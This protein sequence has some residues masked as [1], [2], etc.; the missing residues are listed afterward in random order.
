MIGL[1][2]FVSRQR[3]SVRS[4]NG[5]QGPVATSQRPISRSVGLSKVGAIWVSK[6]GLALFLNQYAFTQ[7]KSCC[8]KFARLDRSKLLKLAAKLLLAKQVEKHCVGDQI[9]LP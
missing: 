3:K 9:T 6:T 2:D 7:S 5:N 4:T 1:V 8:E